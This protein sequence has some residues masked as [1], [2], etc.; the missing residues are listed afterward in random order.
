MPQGFRSDSRYGT[1][2]AYDDIIQAASGLVWLNHQVSGQPHY[3]P[4]VL[5]DKICGMQIAQSVLAALHYREHGGTGQHIEVPMADNHARLQPG[6]STWE[7]PPGG[8][9]SLRLGP[10]AQPAAPSPAHRRRLDVHPAAQRP[11]LAGLHRLR[12]PP[13]TG[14]PTRASP[15]APTAARNADAFYPLLA[16]L[17]LRHTNAEWQAFWRPGGHRRRAPCSTWPSAATSAY[18]RE[19]GLL[20]EPNTP[21]MGR[22]RVIGRPVRLLGRPGT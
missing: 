4:T 5:A 10:L 20:Y 6:P 18:A 15:P 13:R 11:Q 22:Y 2:A 17:T 12:G 21:P 7:R 9:R 16:G 1:H 14:P 19:G 3:V 8:R